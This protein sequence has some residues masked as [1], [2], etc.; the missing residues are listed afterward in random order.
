M[1]KPE[2]GVMI[3]LA[4]GALVWAI[5]TNATPSIADIR[6]A[7]PMDKDVEGS[8]KVATRTSAAA[9]SSIALIAKD[10]TIFIIGG[11]MVIAADW[12]T[13][14]AN[15]IHPESGRLALPGMK[16]SPA[17]QEASQPNFAMSGVGF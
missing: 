13:R 8:R 3:G 5:F 9:V 17:L 12:M 4:T 15:L 10:P 2:S 7:P 11:F 14:H 1:L 16:A 6:S